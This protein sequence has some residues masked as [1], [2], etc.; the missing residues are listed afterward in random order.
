MTIDEKLDRILD[1]LEVLRTDFDILKEHILGPRTSKFS[2]KPLSPAMVQSAY[3]LQRL[4][5]DVKQALGKDVDMSATAQSLR[6]GTY[7]N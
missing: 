7:G 2:D 6:A 4:V 1:E 3:E 5:D